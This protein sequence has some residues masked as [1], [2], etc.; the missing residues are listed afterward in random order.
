MRKNYLVLEKKERDHFDRMARWYDRNYGYTLAFT[1]Y[2]IK[3]KA[4]HFLNLVKSFQLEKNSKIL[5]VGC[6]TGAYTIEI[7]KNLG[8]SKMVAIDISP[9]IIKVAKEKTNSSNVSYQVKS[10]YR[11]GFN[12]NSFDIVFGFY[13]FHHLE[14]RKAIEEI[15]RIIK[16]G[17]LAFFCEPNM[18]NPVVYLI[19]SLKY[20]KS[21][22]GDSEDEWAVNPLKV[23]GLWKG[24]RVLENRSS[25]FLPPLM[26]IATGK[27]I[28]LDRLSQKIF[29]AI[30]LVN[31]FGGSV[32]FALQKKFSGNL[33]IKYKTERKF[34]DNWARKMNVGKINYMGA[35]EG[36]SAVENKYAISQF[37]DVKGKKL[38]DLGCGIGDASIYFALRGAEV[39]AI[40]ISPA[41][42][43]LVKKLARLKRVSKKV[44]AKVMVAEKLNLP[45]NS[46]DFVF[47]N[48]VLHHVDP[49][50]ALSE[51]YRVLKPGGKAAFVEP[52][53]HNF[54]INVY[55]KIADKVRTPTETPLEYRSLKRLTSEKF[56]SKTHKEF[57]LTTLLIFLWYYLV[58]RVNPNKE[59]YWKKIIDDSEKIKIPFSLL[60]GLDSLL[61]D[62]FSFLRKYC[63][64]TV[65]ILTK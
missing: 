37:G 48:G 52:L 46:F 43:K 28:K 58:D 11:T 55:R 59:R 57:H 54:L 4:A 45:S 2:K 3:K 7:A 21:R 20:L 44:G 9:K 49:N 31:K 19:K 17:G 10:I 22:A 34:H 33:E 14:P 23:G 51:V 38:L 12:D 8:A 65:I 56:R 13:V 32:E 15:T 18:L 63:W 61:L 24:F 16:P 25:E 53:E 1:K 29:S 36:H 6:G 50:R 26:P 39:T 62:N 27:K 30:P 35:F 60:N 41:M 42:I 5:E 47:G 64:N 40:D